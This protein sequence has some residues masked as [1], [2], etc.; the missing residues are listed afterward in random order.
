MIDWGAEPCYVILLEEEYP[1]TI[2]WNRWPMTGCK[3]IH[4]CV[5]IPNVSRIQIALVNLNGVQ[6]V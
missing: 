4:R 1:H 2:D 3:M 5:E 6:E